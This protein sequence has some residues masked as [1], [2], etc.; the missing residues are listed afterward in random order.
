MSSVNLG[1]NAVDKLLLRRGGIN[2]YPLFLEQCILNYKFL[3]G[4]L[5]ILGGFGVI[6]NTRVKS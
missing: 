3:G 1:S 4:I 5:S 6:L 2:D